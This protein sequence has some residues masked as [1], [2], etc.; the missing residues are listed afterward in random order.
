MFKRLH[1][2]A[3]VVAVAWLTA[4]GGSDTFQDRNLPMTHVGTEWGWAITDLQQIYVLRSDTEFRDAWLTHLPHN[5][6]ATNPPTEPP[7]PPVIDF[8]Q[9]MVLGLTLGW[10]PDGCHNL[11]IRRV[12]EQE[13]RVQ[14]EY[15]VSRGAGAPEMMGCTMA[16]VPLTAFVIV[17]RVEKPVSFVETEGR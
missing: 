2:Q 1:V 13:K 9:N 11:S 5:Q 6:S 4:C 3:A 12:V 15:S 14:V 17:E 7:P 16:I 10:G 8:S